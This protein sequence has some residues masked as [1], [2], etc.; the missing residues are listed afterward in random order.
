MKNW[1]SLDENILLSIINMKLRNYYSSLDDLCDDLQIDQIALETKLA[2]I[3]YN[4]QKSNN[5]FVYQD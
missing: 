1:E 5:Q 2:T 3:N 4:Y